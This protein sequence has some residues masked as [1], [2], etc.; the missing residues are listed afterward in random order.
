MGPERTNPLILYYLTTLGEK[1]D[2]TTIVQRHKSVM[3]FCSKSGRTEHNMK[4]FFATQLQGPDRGNEMP[5]FLSK[6]RTDAYVDSITHWRHAPTRIAG[7]P[8]PV[9]GDVDVI[10]DL[11]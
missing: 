9:C 5:A 6:P 2:C 4:P 7:K 10:I 3:V 1:I 11:L 8:A